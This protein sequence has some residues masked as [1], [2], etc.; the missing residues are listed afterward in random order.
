MRDDLSAPNLGQT[1][2][3]YKAEFFWQSYRSIEQWMTRVLSKGPINVSTITADGGTI[4]G[5]LSVGGSIT[6]AGFP[7]SPVTVSDIPPAS[8]GPG[9][10]WWKSD[11]GNLYVYYNDGTSTQWV[12][13]SPGIGAAGPPGTPGADSTVPGPIGPTGPAGTTEIISLAP[14]ASQNNYA[15]GTAT[16]MGVTTIIDIAPTI[17][18][19]LTGIST[20]SWEAGKQITVR[21]ATSRL[22]A[23][24]RAII[25]TRNSSLSSAANRFQYPGTKRLPLILMPEETAD[26][27]FNGTDLKLLRCMRPLTV[28]GYFDW[29]FNGTFSGGGWVNG[30]DADTTYEAQS[31]DAAGEPYLF[32]GM[33]TG[34][35][36]TGRSAI[37]DNTATHRAGAGALLS[38]SRIN[39]PV[40]STA[41]EEFTARIGFTEQGAVPV[42]DEISWLY[43]RT[44]T[45]DWQT[46][47]CAN[48]VATTTTITG[49]AV[50]TGTPLL[51][52]FVNGDGTRVEYFYSNDDGVTWTVTP[53]AHTANIP[54]TT[55]RLFGFGGQIVKSVGITSREF[56]MIYS[57][58]IGWA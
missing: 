31:V 21:N 39:L 43:N 10:L 28:T 1:D 27:Y 5:D 3:E 24:S 34:T 45:T 32:L 55:A 46:R 8:A 20:A 38:L 56:R 16:G 50:A 52:V 2:R 15:T 13:A 19:V 23:G 9:A 12:V 51:G 4:S 58:T 49:F 18:M 11:E 47:S 35:T 17:T 36:A 40:L 7:F 29:L 14:T 44:T 48:S 53:T 33:Q 42:P 57:G 22:G 37:T 26:F 54:N 30:T 41:A 25:L 6:I